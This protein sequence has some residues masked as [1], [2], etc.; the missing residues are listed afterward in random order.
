MFFK[1]FNYAFKFFG[2]NEPAHSLLE[3]ENNSRHCWTEAEHLDGGQSMM[4]IA[5]QPHSGGKALISR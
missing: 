4:Y 5:K 2:Y 1:S 3:A